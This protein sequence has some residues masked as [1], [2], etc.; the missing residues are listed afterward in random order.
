MNGSFLKAFVVGVEI[1][2]LGNDKDKDLSW[3]LV[4]S[5]E[6]NHVWTVFSG[7]L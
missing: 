2:G 7:I 5:G 6:S 3:K 4:F 1:D